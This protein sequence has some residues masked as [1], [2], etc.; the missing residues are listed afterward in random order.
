VKVFLN[1]HAGLTRGAVPNLEHHKEQAE[2]LRNVIREQRKELKRRDQQI[3]EQAENL[4]NER[5]RNHQHEKALRKRKREIFQLR[6]ELNAIN[7]LVENAQD[8]PSAPQLPP[9]KLKMGALPDFAL[10]GAPRSGTSVF[11]GVLT[12]HPNVERAA[13]KEV[14]YFDSYF[15]K[16]IEWYR[17]CFP[18]PKWKNGRSSI[19]G[20]ATPRYL[21]HPLVPER[22][23]QVV[24]EVRLIVLLRNPVDRAYSHYHLLVRRGNET[25]SFEEAIEEELAWLLDE[26]NE[27]SEHERHSSVSHGRS[28]NL[29]ATGIYVDQLLRWRRF[30]GNEQMLVLKSEIFFE[31]TT[32]TLKL[33]QDFLSLPYRELDRQPHRTKKYHYEPMDPAT[34]KRLEDYFEPHNRRL[35]EYL[36]VDFG[37]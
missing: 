19:T 23:A 28:S 24:P 18:P 4:T 13:V 37:W 10:I 31:R 27:S 33:V 36:G 34:R 35:Y 2:K 11:Y 30:F 6:N 21:S 7:G 3:K 8:V 15:D 5:Q 32:D 14:H 26:E 1:L 17:Q 16:G 22:M 12:Q 29:L 20:E 25:R 9:G